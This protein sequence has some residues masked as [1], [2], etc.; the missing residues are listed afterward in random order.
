MN[1]II[2]EILNHEKEV[3]FEVT[4]TTEIATKLL[5][6]KNHNMGGDRPFNRKVVE[7]FA[8]QMSVGDWYVDG[9]VD[10]DFTPIALD[11]ITGQV[12]DG[13][14]RLIAFLKSGVKNLV[15]KIMLINLKDY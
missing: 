9:K 15:F 1:I 14:L 2:K 4:I 10:E 6:I 13:R 5:S 3:P 8:K 11:V 7:N 12:I